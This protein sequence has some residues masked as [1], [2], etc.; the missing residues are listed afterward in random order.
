[1]ALQPVLLLGIIA[2][3]ASSIAVSDNS[4]MF[5]TGSVGGFGAPNPQ[6]TD[7]SG[8]ILGLYSIG[9]PLITAC[10]RLASAADFFAAGE[11]LP[12]SRFSKAVYADGVYGMKYNILC[13]G[14]GNIIHNSDFT[15]FALTNA[16]TLLE[17]AAGFVLPDNPDVIYYIDRTKP[18]TVDGGFVTMPFTSTGTTTYEIAYE[19][20]LK[21]LID[22][23]GD[24]CLTQDIG[25][26]AQTGCAD[27]D[28]RNIWSRF[29]Q[30]IALRVKFSTGYLTD[31]SQMAEALADYCSCD[32]PDNPCC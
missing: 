7:V 2:Q 14:T 16:A 22:K 28:F 27:N 29:K 3:D 25:L 32:N 11:I 1:M 15:E 21:L 12:A 10:Y 4:G 31:A 23:A 19:G 6:V 8:V 9:T 24:R 20:D 5:V 26:W 17:N 30:L 18:L 13:N